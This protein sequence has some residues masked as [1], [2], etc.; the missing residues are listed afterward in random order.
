MV[1][2]YDIVES[3]LPPELTLPE[4]RRMRLARRRPRYRLR[5]RFA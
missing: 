4:W 3:S 5:I 2:A 1:A